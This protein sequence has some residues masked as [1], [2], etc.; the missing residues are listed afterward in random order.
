MFKKLLLVSIFCV[1]SLF[2][3]DVG[4]KL[5]TQII[6]DLKL[7][8]DKVYVLDFF[9]SWC[10]SCKIE[11][12]LISTVNTQI[13]KQ[14]YEIIGIDSDKDINK[15][16]AFVKKL[17]L[18]FDVIYD[19]QSKFI[20]KFNPIGV[21]AIYYIKNFEVKKIIYGAVNDI[22]KKILADLQS[23]GEN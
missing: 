2:A 6:N 14:K 3:F 8:K 11:L 12:P 16:K 5:D 22:D 21:P 20:S 17:N 10:A 9:A 13:D 18:N 19:N 1:S 15:G 7:T 4:D 23:L